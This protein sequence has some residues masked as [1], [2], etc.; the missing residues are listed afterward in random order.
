VSETWTL[1]ELVEEVATRIAR[2][3]APKN[4][5]VRAVPD[6]RTVRYYQTIGLLD[7][8]VATRGRTSLFGKRHL[9]QVVAIKRLQTMGRSLAEI[10]ALWP[11]LD[12][13][14]LTRMSG[15]AFDARPRTARKDFWRREPVELPTP[16]SSRPAPIE[17][18]IELAP[19]VTLTVS[20]P[21]T[22]FDSAD[23]GAIRAAAAPLLAELAR[24]QRTANDREE[25]P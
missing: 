24:R 23:L 7:R 8:P 20:L 21:D 3:P 14:T 5:Q 4:G 2:L 15:V 12:D 1:S 17:L 11:T 6:E 19:D 10:Q 16:P 13:D 25:T 18:R 9:A 22:G